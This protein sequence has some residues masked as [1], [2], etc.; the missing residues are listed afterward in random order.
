MTSQGKTPSLRQNNPADAGMKEGS[1]MRKL[2]KVLN[3]T[4][5][6]VVGFNLFMLLRVGATVTCPQIGQSLPPCGK[7][8]IINQGYSKCQTLSDGCCQYTCDYIK[9]CDNNYYE[10]CSSGTFY[11]GQS[12]DSASGKCYSLASDVVG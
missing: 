11:S 1:R 10:V 9:A 4:L 2:L 7:K 12:C 3:L 6:L 5:A 8:E